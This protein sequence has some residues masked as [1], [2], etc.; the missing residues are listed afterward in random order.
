MRLC[1][2]SGGEPRLMDI[3]GLPK[4]SHCHGNPERFGFYFSQSVFFGVYKRFGCWSSETS[5]FF[6]IVG[7]CVLLIVDSRPL[8]QR[9]IA[10]FFC[11]FWLD[12]CLDL[13]F[14][15]PWFFQ[16]FDLHCNFFRVL[17]KVN[18]FYFGRTP[19]RM[20]W[21]SF[22]RSGANKKG[23]QHFDELEGSKVGRYILGCSP[24]LVT[25]ATR[26]L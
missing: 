2:R 5:P 23:T 13:F 25:V 10:N 17:V 21:T 3:L 12:S 4:A 7:H 11:I 26:G 14:L 9:K 6:W 18:S 16:L 19:T 15:F 22:R 1:H 8:F 20:S 24:I